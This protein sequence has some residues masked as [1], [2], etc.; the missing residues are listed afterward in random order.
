MIDMR[1]I[2]IAAPLTAIAA[3]VL[4]SGVALASSQFTQTSNITL[5]A[6]KAGASTGFKAA[7]KS[8][9]P[10]EPGGKPQ[11]L[12]TL[13]ITFP[14]ATKFNFK[15]KAITPCTAS[16]V[17]IKGTKGAACPAM[18]RIGS[19]GA[20]ANGAP[21]F[22]MLP[23]NAIAYA[24]KSDLIF[25]LTPKAAAGTVLVLHGKV[26][27]NKV[28]VAVP[29]LVEGPLTIV[30]TALELN[31]NRIGNG[32]SAFVT[33]GK[34]HAGRFTVGSSFA[35]YTGATKQLTSSSRCSS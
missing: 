24:S 10:G 12:K 31:V 17:E 15:S 32:K 16:D 7:L 22:P 8:S 28:T 13:T 3:L 1:R 11:A 30:I 9:D 21:V 27:A 34:C 19:G 6:T 23:E 2:R 20:E 18:S 35:Y 4:A 14:P 29:A 25:L 5:T 26:A 33:A